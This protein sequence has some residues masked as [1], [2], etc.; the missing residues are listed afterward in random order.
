MPLKKLTITGMT[1]IT[2]GVGNYGPW[3]LYGVE[4]VNEDGQPINETLKTFQE[5]PL[6]QLIEVEIERKETPEY[7]VEFTIKKPKGARYGLRPSP[8]DDAYEDLKRRVY[9]LEQHCGLVAPSYT[10]PAVTDVPVASQAPV[11][12]VADLD[13]I[14]F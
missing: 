13:E 10:S 2:S 14:P 7:G 12:P 6:D 4:A 8:G 1:A 11:A 3:T 5:L 9:A